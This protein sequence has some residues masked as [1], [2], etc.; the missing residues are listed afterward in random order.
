M[1]QGLRQRI[2]SIG[3]PL[4]LIGG[5]LV[6]CLFVMEIG[7]RIFIPSVT[8]A[9]HG[10]QTF[11]NA[12]FTNAR[13][14]GCTFYIGRQDRSNVDGFVDQMA[15]AESILYLQHCFIVPRLIILMIDLRFFT[16]NDFKIAVPI[17][18]P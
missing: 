16:L 8:S 6:V 15:F 5:S 11:L 12:F 10:I 17:K 2:G 1:T 14:T 13:C 3:S 7:V 18:I 4:V 9:C